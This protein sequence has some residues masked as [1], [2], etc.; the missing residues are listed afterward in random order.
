MKEKGKLYLLPA[1]LGEEGLEAVPSTVVARI[2][3]LRYFIAEKAKTARH[4]IKSTHPPYAISELTIFE[5]NKYTSVQ[6]LPTFL[7]PLLEGHDM[8]LLSEAGCPAVADPGALIVELAHQ[9]DIEVVPMVGP[10]SLLLALMA[11]G[12][13]GQQF[14]FNG[15]LSPKRAILQKELKKL[16]QNSARLHQTQLFI[17]TPYRNQAVLETALEALS[18][19]TLF[20]IAANLTLP[21][22]YV[23]TCRI[24]DWKKQTI[25]DLNKQPAV[26]LVYAGKKK[27]WS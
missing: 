24:R 18:P 4:Y 13:N 5:R 19:D 22:Q 25:P 6:E 1:P 27:D 14:C 16:E 20:C 9:Q 11:S 15:Y 12:M 21:D 3:Q 17:E 26:F 2:H 10:S 23:K 7:K 8:G